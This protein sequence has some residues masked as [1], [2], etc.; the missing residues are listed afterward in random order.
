MM[1]RALSIWML[2][3]AIPF[4]LSTLYAATRHRESLGI[5]LRGL[6]GS[7]LGPDIGHNRMMRTMNLFISGKWGKLIF[8]H[9]TISLILVAM[10]GSFWGIILA[11]PIS[12]LL[13]RLIASVNA[14]RRERLLRESVVELIESLTHS[15]EGGF[16]VLQALE[17][18][19]EDIHQPLSDELKRTLTDLSLGRDLDGALGDLGQRVNDPELKVLLEVIVLLRQSGGNLPEILRRLREMMKQRDDLRRFIRVYTTQGRWSG[20]VISFLPAAFLGLESLLSPASIRPLFQT[21]TGFA[22]LSTGLAL[23]AAGFLCIRRI[24]RLEA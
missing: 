11:L 20:Y 3:V 6:R 9:T 15:L 23:E 19:S 1:A 7:P 4:S 21:P 16:S 13:P 17:F 14:H 10:S 18:A 12:L 8:A 22:V 5:R 2:T 24:S